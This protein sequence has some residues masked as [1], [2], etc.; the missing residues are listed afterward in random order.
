MINV[1]ISRQTVDHN[2]PWPRYIDIKATDKS[3]MHN[4][5][6]R[7]SAQKLLNGGVHITSMP[8]C[9][10]GHEDILMF[11]I[12]SLAEKMTL[13]QMRNSGE[14]LKIHYPDGFYYGY[15][16][17]ISGL[18][19]GDCR[20]TLLISGGTPTGVVAESGVPPTPPAEWQSF[21][22]N[23]HWMPNG[24]MAVWMPDEE[25]GYWEMAMG[26]ED[27]NGIELV[28]I[29]T[30][31]VDFRPTHIRVTYD[32]PTENLTI[33]SSPYSSILYVSN[34][35]SGTQYELSFTANRDIYL[36]TLPDS[37]NTFI[38][39]GRITDIQFLGG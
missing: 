11:R 34:A 12:T 33:T 24:G 23:T 18:E 38:D 21:F 10:G 28:A 30:W 29:G 16:K 37:M 5:E 17:K 35:E 27:Y 9:N 14:E 3:R 31:A 7:V 19:S 36:L 4:S 6:Q 20:A 2:D 22:D 15:L 25:G 32:Y 8:Y 39:P 13:L 1:L 26:G